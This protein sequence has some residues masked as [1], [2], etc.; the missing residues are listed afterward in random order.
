MSDLPR[1]IFQSWIHSHEEDTPGEAVYR[2]S[3]YAFPPARGRDGF[4]LRPNGEFI[5]YGIAA[6]DGS[7]KLRGRWEQVGPNAIRIMLEGGNQ[8]E[9]M[10]ILAVEEGVLR[11]ATPP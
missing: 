5:R 4:E 3:T 1:A 2:P 11:L 7:V 8:P 9:T 10:R 6:A